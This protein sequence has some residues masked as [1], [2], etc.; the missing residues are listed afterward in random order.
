[1]VSRSE[2][3]ARVRAALDARDEGADVLIMARTDARG[4]L[5]LDE[6]LWRGRAFAE[7]GADLVFVEAPHDEDEMR[8]ICDGIPAPQ[9]ANLVEGGDTPLL[10]PERLEAIGYRI[11]AYPLTLLS[12]ATRAMQDALAALARGEPAPGLLPFAELRALLGFDSYDDALDRYDAE[13][14]R[15]GAERD[16]G[17]AERDRGGAER[18]RG[19]AERDRGGAERDRG[20]SGGAGA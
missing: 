13:R 18:D 8:R 17:G 3:T 7:L 16:R 9:M 5:G 10:A 12:A 20:G 11:A 15:G 14:D 19:G 2:A 4:P 1:V 6:A